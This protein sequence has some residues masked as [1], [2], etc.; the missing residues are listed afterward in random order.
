VVAVGGSGVHRNLGHRR[1]KRRDPIGETARVVTVE[2]FSLQP[3][4]AHAELPAAGQTL[5]ENAKARLA[6]VH[7]ARR[8]P[9]W[10]ESPTPTVIVA[11]SA[12][13]VTTREGTTTLKPGDAQWCEPGRIEL[14]GSAEAPFQAVAVM[15]KPRE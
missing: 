3:P 2:I 15:L 14:S 1:A 5:L 13:V 6:R 10:F 8:Q 9:V 11:E 4:D 7:A 12:G